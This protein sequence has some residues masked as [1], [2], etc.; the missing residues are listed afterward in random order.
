LNGNHKPL[1]SGIGYLPYGEMTGMTYGNGLSL[2]QV[3][4]NQYR[5]TSIAVSSILGW[6]YSYDPNSNITSFLDAF[7]PPGEEALEFAGTY[8]YQ[9]AT[10]KLVQIQGELNVLYGYDANGNITSANNRSFVYDLSNRLIRVEENSNTL[11]QYIYNGLTQRVKK[12]L[13]GESRIFHYDIVGHLIAETSETGQMLAEYIYLGDQIIAMIRP[14]E[15]IFYYH[16]DHLGTPQ[17]LTDETGMVSWKAVY[18]AFGETEVSIEMVEN[19]FRFP[20]QY[21][22][23]ETGLHYNW[24]RYY[25]PKTGRY[26]TSD[27]IGIDGMINLFAYVQNNPINRSDKLGLFDDGINANGGIW[28]GHSD[29]YGGYGLNKICDYTSEDYGWTISVNP[30]SNWRHFRDQSSVETDLRK[31]LTNCDKKN[32]L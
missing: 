28:H 23:Q 1:A 4:D 16:N 29:F 30:F 5:I 8:T 24:H 3:Y 2:G 32:F 11:A 18:A 20:G 6:T 10:N 7:K 13:P 27:P 31:D 25:E 9:E 14:G 26:L 22:D 12:I 17:I 19:P 21:Y 15:Q